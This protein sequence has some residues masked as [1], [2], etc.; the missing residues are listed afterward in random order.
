MGCFCSR[1]LDPQPGAA[2]QSSIRKI[3]RPVWKTQKPWTEGELQVCYTMPRKNVP[4]SGR[5]R[6]YHMTASTSACAT[7]ANGAKA[8][9]SKG[10]KRTLTTMCCCSQAKREEYWD[11]QPHYG[12]DKGMRISCHLR[13]PYSLCPFGMTL[14]QHPISAGDVL[15]MLSEKAINLWAGIMAMLA[16]Q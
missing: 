11:T 14:A 15:Y 16:M 9:D 3:I 4:S 5:S 2:P 1:Y 10:L 7:I 13:Y 8:V 12:G 6:D